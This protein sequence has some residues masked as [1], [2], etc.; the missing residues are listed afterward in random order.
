MC[1]L[2]GRTSSAS[3]MAPSMVDIE[4]YSTL[5]FVSY[6][7]PSHLFH[8]VVAPTYAAYLHACKFN[9]CWCHSASA[10]MGKPEQ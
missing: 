10:H 1:A 5:R 2:A 9:S 3:S 4:V 7:M 8:S 6:V